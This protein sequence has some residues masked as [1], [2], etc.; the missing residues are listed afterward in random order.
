MA[1]QGTLVNTSIQ[2]RD[3]LLS[4][5]IAG[6]YATVVQCSILRHDPHLS[7]RCLS[8]QV[9]VV[10]ELRFSCLQMFN[11][12]SRSAQCRTSFGISPMVCMLNFG[13]SL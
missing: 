13:Q 11:L 4:N 1:T 5:N 2:L 9:T 8:M 10:V 12:R 6:K 3:T 7:V